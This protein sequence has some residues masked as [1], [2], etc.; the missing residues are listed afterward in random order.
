MYCIIYEFRFSSLTLR[1]RVLL[2]GECTLLAQLRCHLRA[3]DVVDSREERLPPGATRGLTE[4][5]VVVH[6]SFY[7]LDVVQRVPP[8]DRDHLASGVV[9]FS[10]FVI[11]AA[12]VDKVVR[13]V[14]ANVAG[15]SLLRSCGR[16]CAT[17]LRTYSV[18]FSVCSGAVTFCFRLGCLVA[19]SRTLRRAAALQYALLVFYDLAVGFDALPGLRF[20]I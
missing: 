16:L 13:I 3:Q 17:N 20:L 7:N 9:R 11:V 1:L 12:P 15:T 14:C 8:V 6:Q 18:T 19:V 4:R 2:L 5:R 10:A